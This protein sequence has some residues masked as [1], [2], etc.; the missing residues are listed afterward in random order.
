MECGPQ[1]S[2]CPWLVELA[3]TYVLASSLA[4]GFCTGELLLQISTQAWPGVLQLQEFCFP[5]SALFISIF[6]LLLRAWTWWLFSP[7]FLEPLMGVAVGAKQLDLLSL[8]LLG[9]L[10]YAKTVSGTTFCYESETKWGEGMG[11]V[12]G[13]L[14]CEYR[15]L[16]DPV[17]FQ[18]WNFLYSVE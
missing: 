18:Y 4:L 8:R 9:L 11:N 13:Q 10:S 7:A 1:C 12:S 14:D 6:Q 17:C 5:Y 2:N 16:A 15:Y 3:F